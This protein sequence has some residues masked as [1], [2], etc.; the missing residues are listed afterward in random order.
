MVLDDEISEKLLI[1]QKPHTEN[2]INALT[3]YNATLDA[4]DTGTGK[5]Y[6]AIALAKQLQLK[7]FIICPKSVISSWMN[8]LNF[9]NCEFYGISNYELIQNTKHY[10]RKDKEFCPYIEIYDIK[11]DNKPAKSYRWKFPKD[12]LVIFDEA[13]R[14]KNKKTNNSRLLFTMVQYNIKILMLSA[15]IADTP[16]NFHIAGYVLNLYKSLRNAVSWMKNADANYNHSMQGVHA[17]LYPERASRMKISELGDLFPSNQVIAEC[18]DMD[19]A[20]EIQKLYD[21]IQDNYELLEKEEKQT[22][23]IGRLIKM[24]QKI[25]M[26]KVP[27]YIELAKKYLEEGLA[28]AIFVNFT[29]SLRTIAEELKTDCIIFGEQ[30]K[31]ER[32]ENIKAFNEDKER[33]IVCNT[34]AGGVGISLHDTNGVYPRISIISPS[35]SAQDVIQALGRIHRAKGQ[36]PVRQRIVYCKDTIEE[37][38]CD[39]MKEKIINIANLNDGETKDYQIDG[40]M[41]TQIEK[42]GELSEYERNFQKLSTLHIKRERLKNELSEVEKN[43]FELEKTIG[44]F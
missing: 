23:G 9:F 8:V 20:P 33:V 28:V 19:N 11:I 41:N 14:C 29:A 13:H 17:V 27:T 21:V 32:D 18:L 36:T 43:I 15:T 26:L 22:S 40:L 10:T 24:R 6:S 25:E 42:D 12:T 5:T 44:L 16:D 7:P 1:Y 35:W 37:K 3:K 2:L 34:R 30:T 38:V 4:S 31:S 39:N